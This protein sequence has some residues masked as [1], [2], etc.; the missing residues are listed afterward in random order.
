MQKVLSGM[1]LYVLFFLIPLNIY[2]LNA[3]GGATV[4]FRTYMQ[5]DTIRD[6]YYIAILLDILLF[7]AV[8]TTFFKIYNKIA[9]I[10][11]I[12]ILILSIFAFL[13]VLYEMYFG[14]TFYYGEVRDK[15]FPFGVNNLGFLGTTVFF[16]YSTILL[17]TP[18]LRT[19]KQKMMC[20]Y[21]VTLFFII[22]FIFLFLLLEKPWRMTIS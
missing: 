13:I 10:V 19:R 9:S 12:Y 17:I 14:S 18:K 1:V 15:Q 7:G 22:A 8:F 16:S 3:S 2:E 21:I 4:M 5:N 11:A 20:S 6:L